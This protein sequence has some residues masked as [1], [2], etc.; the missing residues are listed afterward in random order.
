MKKLILLFIT[1]SFVLSQNLI[2]SVDE[3]YGHEGHGMGLLVLEDIFQ[4]GYTRDL[5]ENWLIIFGYA[6][7]GNNLIQKVIPTET[8]HTLTADNYIIALNRQY[9]LSDNMWSIFGVG[10]SYMTVSWED[11]ERKVSSNFNVIVPALS[12]AMGASPFKF[13]SPFPMSLG[14]SFDI[15]ALLLP[16]SYSET[17]MIITLDDWQIKLFP[18]F[19]FHFDFPK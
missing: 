12:C 16:T 6:H 14:V 15:H 5:N 3:K 10:A 13:D 4:I 17:D 2:L 19:L 8:S 9:F 11:K 1:T 18:G 7:I